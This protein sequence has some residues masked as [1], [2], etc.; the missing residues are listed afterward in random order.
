MAQLAYHVS[1]GQKLWNYDVHQGTVLY[2]ALEDDYPRLQSR[3]FR[4]FGVEGTDHL[5]FSVCAKQIGNGL[6]EQ[7]RKFIREHPD[8]K[9]IT[10][11]LHGDYYFPLLGV[12][13]TESEPLDRW[14][15]LRWE[16]L[17]EHHPVL[18]GQLVANGELHD[19]LVSIDGMRRPAWI[20]LSGR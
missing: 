4:M 17:K 14:A 20:R 18:F 1:S 7:L 8:T 9:L 12:P 19:H 15:H 11:Q 16:Y 10:Y 2:L 3:M 5:F 6:D 13:A